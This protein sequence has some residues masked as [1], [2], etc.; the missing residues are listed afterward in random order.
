MALTKRLRECMNLPMVRIKRL[1]DC[2]IQHDSISESPMVCVH[3]IHE[4]NQLPIVLTN[5]LVGCIHAPM[6]LTIRVVESVN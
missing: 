3:G 4:H 1:G 6:A 5:R 2:M